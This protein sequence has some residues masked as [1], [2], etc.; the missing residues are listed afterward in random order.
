MKALAANRA[1]QAMVSALVRGGYRLV[2]ADI[3]FSVKMLRD[4]DEGKRVV[5]VTQSGYTFLPRR[6]WRKIRGRDFR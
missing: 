2:N 4:T 1:Q 6:I 5:Y 3:P